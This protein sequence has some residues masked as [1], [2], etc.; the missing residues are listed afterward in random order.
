MKFVETIKTHVLYSTNF[1]PESHALYKNVGK[2]GRVRQVTDGNTIRR[3]TKSADTLRI[4]KIHVYCPRV[5]ISFMIL[6][7]VK[8]CTVPS[9][10]NERLSVLTVLYA[11]E[12]S[13]R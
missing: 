8:S 1:F 6:G 4:Q 7:S 3:M 13:W 12:Y 10:V 5:R 11:M 2:Y 9:G